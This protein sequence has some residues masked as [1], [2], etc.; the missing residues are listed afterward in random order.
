MRPSLHFTAEQQWINDPNGLV[1]INGEYH[2]FCQMNPDGSLWGNMSWGHAISRDLL[3]WEQIQPALTPYPARVEGA[4][5]FI[6]SGSALVDRIGLSGAPVGQGLLAYYTAHERCGDD[7]INES[8]A[9][10]TSTNGGRTWF[11]HSSNPVLDLGRRD[12][13][14]PR[15]FW[16]E[17][18]TSMVMAIA[19]PPGQ[20]V[21]F[22]RSG[23][24]L[25]WELSGSFEASGYTSMIWECPDL[26]E[27]PYETGGGS[28]WVLSISSGHQAGAPYTGM[29]YW[30]G[31]FDGT[32]FRA[33]D[34]QP[35]VLDAGKDFY[36]A[37]SYNDLPPGQPP[38]MIGWASNWA[39]ATVT[40]T[41]PWRGMMAI[42]R[43]LTLRSTPTRLVLVQRPTG[44]LDR[45]ETEQHST[46][47][48]IDSPLDIRWSVGSAQDAPTGIEF[49]TDGGSVFKIW[50]DRSTSTLACDRHIEGG[51]DFARTFD[52]IDSAPLPLAWHG[53][54]I[55]VRVIFDGCIA[56]VFACEGE[57]VLTSLVFC[58]NPT[59]I[60]PLGD[61]RSLRVCRILPI[62]QTPEAGSVSP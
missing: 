16:H 45:R 30:I 32:C 37:V 54:L 52:G 44:Q 55:D 26:V 61:P 56:E 48:P 53:E 46:N 29:Q 51:G 47:S 41:A 9:V 50:I 59:R 23:D 12:F 60:V 34:L 38:I 33:D 28:R 17:P 20:R 11:R 8:V 31:E 7:P 40:P 58:S 57:L 18:S 3:S 14:D 36:A 25:S 5:T 22:Y 1:Y 10:A 62:Y 2:L 6:F 15:V 4:D 35:Q 49:C 13:R 19:D 43:E 39:Y 21:E 27:V 24:G 42:P